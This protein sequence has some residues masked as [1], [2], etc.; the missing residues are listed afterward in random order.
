MGKMY[1]YPHDYCPYCYH[2]IE[3][4]SF[5]CPKCV[6]QHPETAV[7]QPDKNIPL[8]YRGIPLCSNCGSVMRICCSND[9]CRNQNNIIPPEPTAV[10]AIAGFSS[11]GK[12]TYL[13]DV[14]ASKSSETGVLVSAKSHA[15]IEW[16]E[17]NLHRIQQSDVLDST[18]KHADN[19]SSVV[20][21]Q[22]VAKKDCEEIILSLTDRPGEES[23][24]MERL[25][26]LNYLFCADYIILLLDLLNLPGMSEELQAKDIDFPQQ[27]RPPRAMRSPSKIS[28]V[29]WNSSRA[30]REKRFRCLSALPSG[31]MRKKPICARRAFLSDARAQIPRRFWMPRDGWIRSAGI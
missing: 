26:S 20:G 10:V 6:V 16:R 29:H 30:K 22:S 7:T 4:Y 1:R 2:K 5:Y 31:T 23:Q 17:Q 15:L 27:R 19:F 9:A 28:S 21:F 13:L 14:V 25:A 18:Q 8:D 3:T 24:E 11:S 12:S